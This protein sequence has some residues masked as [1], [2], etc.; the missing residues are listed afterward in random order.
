MTVRC[1]RPSAV[2]V[3]LPAGRMRLR[4][5][6]RLEGKTTAAVNSISQHDLAKICYLYY[7]EGRTQQEISS[8]FGISR[9]KVSRLLKKARQEGLVSIQ[10]NAPE[11]GLAE[12]EIELAQKFDLKQVRIV[13]ARNYGAE[14]RPSKIGEAGARH[15][16]GVIQQCRVLGV[17]WGRSVSFVVENV[18]P[19]DTR[20]LTV[21]QMTGGMG[22]I[23]GTDATA[24]TMALGQKLRAKAHV[25]QA[26][27]IVGDRGVRDALLREKQIRQAISVARRA[28]AAIFGIGLPTE[29]GLLSSAGFLNK[30]SI[31]NLESAGVVGV[32]CGRFFDINGNKCASE[33]DD[34]II[35]LDLDEV[36]RIRHKVVI[37]FGSKK[38]DAIAGAMRGGLMDVLIT[39]DRTADALLGVP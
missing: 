4:A 1:R 22:A 31:A 21:V 9:F 28:D 19:A 6:L 30:K 5:F 3:S 33:L 16:A 38:V 32:I 35:G 8:T 27:V 18:E 7:F 20:N 15:L 2:C 39:D 14:D 24:L 17:A 25:I 10:I 12:R 11:A 37:A 29:D 13:S 36:K 26:P 23:A 34:Q